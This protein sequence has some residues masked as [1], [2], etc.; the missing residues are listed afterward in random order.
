MRKTQNEY[1]YYENFNE[2][3]MDILSLAKKIMPNSFLFLSAFI[4][5]EQH[6]LKVSKN[7]EDI[8][9]NEGTNIPL[10]S[11]V[12]SRINFDKRKPL[13]YKNLSE[14]TGLKD[15]KN[16]LLMANVNA[17]VGIPVILSNGEVFGTL[18][19]V[20]EKATEFDRNSIE[21]I[22][23]LAKMFSYYLELESMA[24]R[25]H[26]TGCYNRYFLE[27]FF[28]QCSTTEEGTVFFLDLDGFKIIND[29]LGHEAGDFVLKEVSLRIEKSIQQS[30]LRGTAFRLGGD[31][32][33][34][35]LVGHNTKQILDE[36]AESLIKTLSS[37]DF[38][39]KDF[40]LSVSIGIYNYSKK[41]TQSIREILKKADNALYR[42]KTSGKNTYRYF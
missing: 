18:C 32:F 31:E 21:L 5:K 11:A 26:L 17:Y 19:A 9:I 35:N 8:Y 37:W 24:Y 4:N 14:E 20:Q 7:T 33:I 1:L 2:L 3:V 15:L 42:A 36:Y 10:D 29:Q 39:T 38:H 13:I 40:H 27:R 12:C 25:D 30:K 16:T 6:I 28:S 22:E 41:E 34:V 23:K